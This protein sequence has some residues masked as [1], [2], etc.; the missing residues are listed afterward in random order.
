MILNFTPRSGFTRLSAISLALSLA[1]L[2]CN[3]TPKTTDSSTSRKPWKSSNVNAAAVRTGY[4]SDQDWVS[5]TSTWGPI[6]KNLAYGEGNPNDRKKITLSGTPYDKGLGTHADSTINFKL[7]PTCSRFKASLG[8]DDQVRWQTEYGNVIFQVYGDNAL[9]FDSQSM[10]GNTP[11]K[12]IDVNITG[13]SSLKLVVDQN[14]NAVEGDQSDWYDQADWA[15]ARVECSTSSSPTPTPP[16]PPQTP[17]GALRTGFVSDQMDLAFNQQ[18]GWGPIEINMAN[19]D[20]LAQKTPDSPYFNGHEPPLTLK[21]GVVAKG[22][23]VHALSSVE[24]P[25]GGQCSS[26]SA[27]VGLDQAYLDQPGHTV[28]FQVWVDGSMKKD[29]G[30]LN[31]DSAPVKFEV[32]LSGGKTLKLIVTDGGDGNAYDHADWTDAK[33][34]CGTVSSPPPPAAP[35]APPSPTPTPPA[36]PTP[37]VTPPSPPSP[38]PSSGKKLIELGWDAMTADFVKSNIAAMEQRPFNGFVMNLHAGQTIFNK[39]AYPDSAYTND[40][41]DLAATTFTKLNDNFISIW[42]SREN[43]WSWFDDNDWAATVTNARNFAKTAKIGRFKG[44]FF[45]PEPYEN[46]PWAYNSG[47]YPNQSFNEV[48]AKVRQ[49]G[50]EFMNALQSEMPNVKVLTLFG[51]SYIKMRAE[52]SGNLEGVDWVLLASFIDGMLSTINPQAQLIDGNEFSYYNYL[53]KSQE[54]D[55]FKNSKNAARSLIS[56]ENQA[57]YDNQVKTSQA[58]FIDAL[59]K[60]L[61][62]GDSDSN[63]PLIGCHLRGR[64]ERKLILENHIYQAL[65]TTDEYAWVYSEKMNWWNSPYPS[66]AFPTDLEPVIASAMQKINANQPLGFDS[67]AILTPAA[68][69]LSVFYGGGHSTPV[70]Y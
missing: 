37:P 55:A 42:G 4:L 59:L 46:N 24:F 68:A 67:E 22:L 51:V 1:L 63:E 9:L 3:T 36:P 29:S 30:V 53:P 40:R 45:D 39:T 47:L 65:R 14:K 31:K 6:S 50:G 70:C 62:S 13:H 38:P 54:F 56:A 44:F 43:G 66:F 5:A 33:V 64:N 2:A 20:D 11:T 15:S 28:N 8:I 23:G 34:V 12:E 60:L 25:L 61:G 10:T 58:V 52:Q 27:V 35:P 49:R 16:V 18:N 41:N 32:E 21:T 69:R 17:A 26:F 19:G 7:D 57:K 48:Q